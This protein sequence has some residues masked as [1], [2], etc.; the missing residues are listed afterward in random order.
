MANHSLEQMVKKFSEK[1]HLNPI[2]I[3]QNPYEAAIINKQNPHAVC[4]IIYNNDR[5]SYTTKTYT[6]QEIAKKEQAHITHL[7]K[8]GTCSSLQDLAVYLKKPDLTKPGKK[9]AMLSWLKSA[10]VLCFER[11]GFSKPCALTWYYNARN[12][13]KKCFWTCMASFVKNESSNLS[14]GSLNTC[15]QCDQDE[16]GPGFVDSAGRTRRNSGLISSIGRSVK[17]I[18][19]IVHDYY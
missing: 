15:L 19:H 17:E 12:T 16:S 7:G 5:S 13:A 1:K 9:C 14:D 10:S 18:A 2:E 11:L 6:N 3:V 8:C 4:G